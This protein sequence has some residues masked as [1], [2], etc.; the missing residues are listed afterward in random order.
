MEGYSK[1]LPHRHCVYDGPIIKEES[2][3][4]ALIGMD[5]QTL[6]AVTRRWGVEFAMCSSAA[7]GA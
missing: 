1:Y 4:R 2:I 7:P 3:T 5:A 6:G